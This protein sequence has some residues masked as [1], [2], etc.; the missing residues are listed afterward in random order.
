MNK[1]AWTAIGADQ[2]APIDI[3]KFVLGK[4]LH[5]NLQIVY[6]SNVS[7]EQSHDSVDARRWM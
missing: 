1:M 5:I 7:Y 3:K 6:T 2:S 4:G